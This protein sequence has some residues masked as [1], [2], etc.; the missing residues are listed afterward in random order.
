[1]CSP[2]VKVHKFPQTR[3]VDFPNYIFPISYVN[4]KQQIQW[5]ILFFLL[6]FFTTVKSY[7]AFFKLSY[8]RQKRAYVIPS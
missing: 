4:T 5:L 3:F 7:S 8:D 2:T 6:L 1:M